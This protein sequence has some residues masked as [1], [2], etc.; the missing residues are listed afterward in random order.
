MVRA[1]QQSVLDHVVNGRLIALLNDHTL[2][3]LCCDLT[4]EAGASAWVGEDTQAMSTSLATRRF[5]TSIASA[6]KVHIYSV[7]K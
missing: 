7:S 4:A 3:Q 6:L 1:S 2:L 5:I